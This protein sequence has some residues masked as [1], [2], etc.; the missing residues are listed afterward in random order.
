[1]YTF[2][3]NFLYSSKGSI[4]EN[5]SLFNYTISGNGFDFYNNPEIR[6]KSFISDI[7][8]NLTAY[9]ETNCPGKDIDVNAIEKTCEDNVACK[10]DAAAT[11]NTAFGKASK[12][13]EKQVEEENEVLGTS[14]LSFFFSFKS[15]KLY[16]IVII[17][18]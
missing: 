12:D 3:R 4:S 16:L 10:V 5:E 13:T 7:L 17:L 8:N 18:L 6:P 9:L 14:F 11:C 1:M 15:N 2:Q